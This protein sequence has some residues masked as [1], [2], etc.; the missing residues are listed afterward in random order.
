MATRG[1][2]KIAAKPMQRNVSSTNYCKGAPFVLIQFQG[3]YS[4]SYK[5]KG[6][7][8]K[9]RTLLLCGGWAHVRPH[10]MYKNYECRLCVYLMSRSPFNMCT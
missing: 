7:C 9:G 3:C 4:V 8:L 6:I 5:D 10:G 1:T 2:D